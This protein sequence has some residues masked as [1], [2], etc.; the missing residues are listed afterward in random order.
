M[1]RRVSVG[2]RGSTLA[3]T[4]TNL[5]VS[6]LQALHMR[7]DFTTHVIHTQGDR[8][9]K[10]SLHA[11]GGQGAFVG[12]IEAALLRGEID[13]AV[14]S[15]KDMPAAKRPGLALHPALERQDPRDA[16]VSR[17][18]VGLMDLPA[19]ARVGTGSARRLAQL[20]QLRPDLDIA[21]IRGNVDTRLRKLD[22]GDYDA[23]VLASAGLLRLGLEHRVSQYFSIEDM[24]PAPGQGILAVQTRCDDRW[25]NE[26]VAAIVHRPTEV[27]ARAERAFLARLEAG[28]QLPVA[29]H[30]TADFAAQT[31]TLHTMLGSEDGRSV[32]RD[33][34][35]APIDDAAA[36]GEQMAE[37]ALRRMET[38]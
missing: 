15:L 30:A 37:A 16:L 5:V 3:L 27:A 17:D 18:N 25:L 36:L 4:Q 13:L 11:I 23:I 24:I 7:V 34:A 14:H 38:A 10:A 20:K 26:I 1:S 29:A 22:A 2:T 21:D 33:V 8:N 32:V 28:C 31:L 19:G 35:T 9:Q 12:E 6:A